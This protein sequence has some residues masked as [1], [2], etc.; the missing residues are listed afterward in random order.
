MASSI[1]QIMQSMRLEY[2]ILSCEL[3]RG[4]S[5]RR[6]IGRDRER[7]VNEG[8]RKRVRE[9]DENGKALGRWRAREEKRVSEGERKRE[10]G[11][12]EM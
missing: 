12:S 7:S 2:I 6:E 1:A 5:E 4:G 9:R 11:I 8:K 3:E 10:K